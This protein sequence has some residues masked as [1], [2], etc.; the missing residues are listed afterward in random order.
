MQFT[1]NSTGDLA[2]LCVRRPILASVLSMLI[3]LAGLAALLAV[4]IRELPDVDRPVVTVRTDYPG[5]T[6]ATIDAQLT[7]VIEGAVGRVPGLLSISSTSERGRSRVVAEFSDTVDM[8]VAASDVRDAVGGIRRRLPKEIEEPVIIKADSDGQPVMRLAVLADDLPA[9]EL[10]AIVE[11]RIVDRLS[12]VEGV[13][14]VELYGL[15]RPVFRVIID[16]AAL[17]SRGM[18][19][20]EVQAALLT[21]TTEAPAGTFKA[22]DQSL[23]VRA[24][25]TAL[26]PAE[27]GAIYINSQTRVSDIAR[28]ELGPAE[29]QT[30]LRSNGRAGV[31]LGIIRQAQ[32]N[33]IAI[34]RN[35]REAVAELNAALPPG[36]SIAVRSDDAVFINSAI[37]EVSFTLL[38]AT[39]LVIGI[40]FLFFRSARATFIPAVTVPVAII[41]TIAGV[42]MMGF[43]INVLTLLALVMAT[44][45]VVD[46]A[47]VVLENI[48]RRRK[49]GMGPRAAA[50]LGARQVFFA[51]LATTATL[52]AV[53]IPI[54]FLPGTASSL[55]V[56]FGFVLAVSVMI[57]SFVALTLAPMLASRILK[58]APAAGASGGRD[59]D[60][61]G[62]FGT[63]VARVY[64]RTLDWCLRAPLVL[65]TVAILF[66]LAA[67]I[68]FRTLPGELTPPEDRGMIILVITG[69][70]GVSLEY[71]DRKVAEV[72]ER[73]QPLVDRGEVVSVLSVVGPGGL[74]RAFV[75]VSLAE[76]SKRERGQRQILAE[77]NRSL[78]QVVGIRIL[79]RNPNSLGIRGAGSGLQF[80]VT[81]SDFDALAVAAENF[82]GELRDRLPRLNN[83][84][85]AF[86]ATQ[87]QLSLR[88]DLAR[89]ADLGLSLQSMNLALQTMLDGR[90][91]GE[92]HVADRAIGVELRGPEGAIRNPGDL[93]NLFVR[94]GGGR[95]VP[96]SAVVMTEETAVAPALRREGQMR[97]VPLQAGLN[98][99][100]D[101]RAAMTEVQALARETLPPG[102]NLR[103]L[104]EAA[105]L[106]QT[107]R[108]MGLTF[109][110]AIVI[111]LLVLSA[112]FESFISAIVIMVTV[113]FG[114]AA[115]VFAMALTG[116]SLNIYSQ[117]GLVM[118]IGLMAKNGILIVEFA[119]QLRDRGA[120]VLD[121]IRD[122]SVIRFRP[123]M[124]TLVST[125][126]GGVPLL[127]STG[128][129]SEA[130]SALGWVI[131]GGLG[132]SALFTLYLTPVAYSVVA[133]FSS[134]R[135]AEEQ[136]L[137]DELAGAE[138]LEKKAQDETGRSLEPTA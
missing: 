102:M 67:V 39:A 17:A 18:S 33:T 21:V 70:Q 109:L 124:M 112:Q 1:G 82:V 138:E 40:I 14:S 81:G 123:V 26:S 116:S 68:T 135:A 64:G 107:S 19:L 136:R 6:P 38:A 104:G 48:E 94:A 8:N 44:G 27:V 49:E 13:A 23:L 113:P 54:S 127:L 90:R 106:D 95:L 7:G 122:A 128:P 101:M 134:P 92:V 110:F 73:I 51:V 57:S 78:N 85:L 43:S 132:L 108:G 87:P 37:R 32:S 3:V 105:T 42:W 117:I 89:A 25:T 133:G 31:G 4:P 58:A 103:F 111:V 28:V 76:W 119:N 100:Y 65:L 118:L 22:G 10:G 16:T 88:V 41:G 45:I 63:M 98:P 69:P 77:L 9:E 131:V 97:A 129:G 137:S 15:R 50:V 96:L 2:S 72:E 53:F 60:L 5:A 91:I 59:W 75:V 29:R 12:A 79:S 93:E 34:S 56:E 115:A 114:L 35:V 52:A 24:E 83:P 80:A 47:I 74:N 55:F 126:L 125:V 11:T 121:A 84:M 61:L 99:G 66:A 30:E 36:V 46:D 130:R 86:D 62:H 20:D 71:T 120:N